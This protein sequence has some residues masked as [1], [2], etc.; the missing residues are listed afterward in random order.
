MRRLR[1]APARL[2]VL[3]G[4]VAPA[5]TG[6]GSGFARADGN[7]SAARGYGADWRRARAAVLAIE[8]LCRFCVEAGR[9][10]AATEVDHIRPFHGLTDPLRLDP[11]NL[12][13]LCA[14]CHRARTGAQAHAG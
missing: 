13:P 9:T 8:P 5:T 7:S 6:A 4:K 1:S 3:A 10:T 12:R 14:P 2:P 11:E